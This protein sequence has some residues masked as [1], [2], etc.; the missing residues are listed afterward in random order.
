VD[1]VIAERFLERVLVN[2]GHPPEHISA[3]SVA[4]FFQSL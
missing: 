4:E 3:D 2:G 1:P